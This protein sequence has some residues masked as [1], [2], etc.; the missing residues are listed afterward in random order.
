M[1][2]VVPGGQATA[3]LIS[4]EGAGSQIGGCRRKAVELTSGDLPFGRAAELS[5]GLVVRQRLKAQ[6]VPRKEGQT[7]P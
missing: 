2:H 6:T 3:K 4:I 5:S 7:A 1:K